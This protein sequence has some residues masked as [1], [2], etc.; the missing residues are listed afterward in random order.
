MEIKMK[1][2][3]SL[4]DLAREIERQ[5]TTKQDLVADTRSIKLFSNTGDSEPSFPTFDEGAV[6]LTV[7]NGEQTHYVVNNLAHKQIAE[8]VG[9]PQKYYQ[10][11]LAEQPEL[12]ARNVNT[13]FE[14]NPERRLIRLLDGNVR[15]FLS[16]RYQRIDNWDVAQTVLPILLSTPGVECLSQEVTESRLY[17]K[18]VTHSV[19]GE[20]KSKRVG[21]IIEAGVMIS[22]SEVGLGAISIKPFLHFLV[23]TNGMVRDKDSLRRAHIGRQIEGDNVVQFLTDET[24]KAEDHAVLLKVRDVVNAAMDATNFRR[25]LDE[26]QATV[27]QRI[28]GNPVEAIKVLADTFALADSEETNI[29]R[30]LIEGAD[31]SKYGLMNAITR[32]S[33]DIE[34]YDRATDLEAIGGALIDL[35]RS[36]WTR[37]AVAA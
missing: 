24:R 6:G 13:W 37:I 8:R 25:M 31:L 16:D 7:N 12:L 23:C 5:K 29:L 9:I 15:A 22:N 19:R 14:A 34:S 28:E 1:Q 18:A 33:A 11:M 21:D 35:P 10:R 3:R 32:A 26:I 17:I 27:D 4:T 20:I 36:D 2:G 30:H